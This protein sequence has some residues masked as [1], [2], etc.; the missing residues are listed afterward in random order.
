MAVLKIS[1]NGVIEWIR[2][3]DQSQ[4]PVGLA[5]ADILDGI[6][7]Y[8]ICVDDEDNIYVGGNY[9][10]PIIA[11]GAKNSCFV[12]EP[13]SVADYTGN[14]Q[15]AAGGMYLIKL[16]SEGN[17][18]N[19]LKSSG[20]DTRDQVCGLDYN[21]G[22]VYFFGNIQGAEGDIVTIGDKDV[23]L[24]NDL[25]NIMYGSVNKDMTVNY[26]GLVKAHVASDGKQTLQ[27]KNIRAIDGGLYLLGSIKGGLGFVAGESAL[28]ETSGTM[29][30]GFA[31]KCDAA[32]GELKSG[33]IYEEGISAYMGM[34]KNEGTIC[35]YGYRMNATEGCVLESFSS[36]DNWT[37]AETDG[38]VSL[39]LGGGSPIAYGCAFEPTSKMLYVMA[40]GN[41]AFTFFGTDEESEAPQGFGGILTAYALDSNTVNVASTMEEA[42]TVAAE[43]GGVNVTGNSVRVVVVNAAGMT[44]ADQVVDGTEF[45]AL[46]AGIHMVNDRKVV[47][48]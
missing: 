10:T 13:R 21:D 16:D 14:S 18:L 30:Q 2:P 37:Y 33:H 43:K 27:C 15:N 22:K 7:P 48:K 25:D 31:L 17:Y 45:I 42:F 8:G 38:K 5:E 9:R 6:T 32:N 44:E 3:F 36:D 4:L 39:M 12:I 41:K 46:P 40:R 19:H 26:V 20:T 34:F 11:W 1:E 28:V 35:L 23:T 29:L 47:V 24:P